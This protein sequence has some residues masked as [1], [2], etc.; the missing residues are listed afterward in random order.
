MNRKTIL[1]II[2]ITA[3]VVLGALNIY[4]KIT[5]K[6]PSDGVFWEEKPE[7]ITALK[8]EIDSPAYLAGIKKGDILYSINNILT[9][10]KIDVS[11]N[12]WLA[13]LSDQK[14]TYQINREG[15]L[16]FPSF[17]LAQKGVNLIYFY[18]ALIGLTTIA[19]SIIV[20]INSKR[21][22]SVPYVFFFYISLAFYSFYIFS[23]TGEMNFL[24]NVF[25]W[26]D[27]GAF[28]VFPPLLLH[29][30]IIFPR[31]KKNLRKILSS[32][33]WLYL[34]GGMLLLAKIF[35]HLP[36]FFNFNDNIIL[37][38]HQ[39]SHKLDLCHFALFSLITLGIIFNDN[40]RASNLI[41]KK[42]LKWIVYGLGIGIIPFFLFY[43]I[44]FL[45]GQV[46][47]KAAELTVVFQAIIPLTFAYSI[48]RYRLVDLEFILKKALT[49]VSSYVV[50]AILYFIVSSQTKIFSENRLNVLILGILAIVLGA[51]L[52]SPIK[53]L[54]QSLLDRA[55]YKRSYKYRKT[56]LS[57]S[58]EISRERNLQKLSQSLLELIAN[59]LE[60]EHIAL[61]LTSDH[62]PSTFYVLKSRGKM[63]PPGTR[64]PIQYPLFQH[65]K[66]AESVSYYTLTEKRE[67][68]REFQKLSSFGFFHFMPLRVEDKF[69]GC[70]GMGKKA[71]NTFLKSE[72]WELLR[73]ISSSVALA[74]EN[75]YLYNQAHSR[76]MELERLKDYS[77]NIIESLTVGVAVLDQKG[78]IIGWNRI[79]EETFSQKKEEVLGKRMINVLGE[80]NFSSL[81]PSDTQHDFRLLSEISLNMPSG[82]KK[83][84]DIAKTPLLDNRMNPY[85]TVIVFED[86]TE[87]ISLQQQLL[88]S[89]KLAS[90]GLLSAGVAHEINTPLTGISSYVQ[91]LQKKLNDSPNAQI[92][93]KIEMQTERVARIVKNLLNLSRNPAESSFHPVNI[94]ECLEEIVS[95]I[96]YKLKNININLELNLSS[97]KPIWAQG[98]NLQQV[99][100][101]ILLNAIDAM[102]NG[103]KLKIQLFQIE[104]NAVVKIQD[105]GTGIKP[106]HLPH[107]FDPFFTTKGIGKGTGL[108]LSIS[109]AVIKEH[110]GH[111]TVE[112]E[113]GKGSLFTIYIPMN[114]DERKR[115]NSLI[116]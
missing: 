98:E 61:L 12:L 20:L 106:Q 56:L 43:V 28:L 5:W 65:L 33:Y 113:V 54:I 15:E 94:K 79:M 77:E 29:F 32:I 73:T 97:I 39:T 78:K 51:T 74:L 92:L 27:E 4:K 23:P 34:P 11:K 53:K 50:I 46:P 1:A 115:N 84:F 37:R 114:L 103:G 95:L 52:F 58:Q 25:Y 26:L 62:E 3:L 76:A 72:D 14:V 69:I 89:E 82:Q 67:L 57:I 24:D 99:F 71:D 38:F 47:S 104:N 112:S 22:F 45:F 80:K 107:I 109:Y 110:E 42:Q 36:N 83:I 10:N 2:I 40:L 102:P 105:T 88:T 87:K 93:E 81:F 48:S 101:N 68:Q 9:K 116:S 75:A 7:G 66:D 59:A 35:I 49:L 70:L 17:Y 91:I 111:I 6:E 44:P 64:I 55:I 8:V 86:V 31:R 60:L 41:I 30:F 13:G 96:D 16:L 21:P 19:I 85:G 108:G 18:L 63:P 100:I 90:I